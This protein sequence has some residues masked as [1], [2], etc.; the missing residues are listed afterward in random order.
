[1]GG[2]KDRASWNSTAKSCSL[3]S[4]EGQWL[5]D[6]AEGSGIEY[7]DKGD[8][9]EGDFFKGKRHGTGTMNFS[10][11]SVFHGELF[12]GKLCGYGKLT[13]RVDYEELQL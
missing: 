12:S 10:D 9:Y 2:E 7:L 5:N 8:V 13:R 4:Y 1:M 11:G 6:M 3:K